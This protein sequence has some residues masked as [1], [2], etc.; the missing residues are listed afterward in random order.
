MNQYIY[1]TLPEQTDILR[2]NLVKI[3]I[4][5]DAE[6]GNAPTV[7]YNI[8]YEFERSE[9]GAGA[10]LMLNG[11][12]MLGTMCIS[13]QGDNYVWTEPNYWKLVCLAVGLVAVLYWMLAVRALRGRISYFFA[14]FSVL[15]KYGFLMKQLVSRDFKTRYKR[16][17]LGV[18]WSLL[19]PLQYERVY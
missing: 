4:T 1:L 8:G 14:T 16:S 5:S 13:V 3:T 2:G 9:V 18:G 7:L 6:S 15:Q 17:V 19:N 11:Q 10:S 12:P